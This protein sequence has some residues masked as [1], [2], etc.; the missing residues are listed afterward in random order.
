MTT[1]GAA[2]LDEKE[3]EKALELDWIEK[4][5]RGETGAFEEL[6]RRYSPRVLNLAYRLMGNR[7]SAWDLSQEAFLA[8]WQ[9]I[10]GFRRES[11]F[12]HWLRTI[13]VHKAI[14]LKKR[15]NPHLEMGLLEIDSDGE[16]R[17]LEIPDFTEEPSA[18]LENLELKKQIK[19]ALALL[20]EHYR[21]TFILREVEGMS[22]EEIAETLK[23]NL[24]T[25]RSRL[26]SARKL[27]RE[28]LKGEDA[29]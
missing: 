7:E 17:E 12:Y 11:S 27:L 19:E 21:V 6:V 29:G 25:V 18:K 9:G 15:A 1:V 14:N 23:V 3:F 5:K 4:A 28:S 22:Y 20:P 24:G 13:I 2:P 8:A 10:G 26:F 16:S